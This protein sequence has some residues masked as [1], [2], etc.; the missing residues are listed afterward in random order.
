MEV[1]ANFE[2]F[3]NS[4]GRFR[5]ATTMK[6]VWCFFV[7]FLS[8]LT[9]GFFL[10]PRCACI[11][12]TEPCSLTCSL[13]MHILTMIPR[14]ANLEEPDF[15]LPNLI[16]TTLWD[17][18]TGHHDMF[19]DEFRE[20]YFRGV[21]DF[22]R[23]DNLHAKFLFSDHDISDDHTWV[24]DVVVGQGGFGVAGLWR[25]KNNEGASV[26]EVVIKQVTG[27][28]SNKDD[29]SE[30]FNKIKREAIVNRDAQR[31]A[32]VLL[33]A[34]K[35]A[36][37]EATTADH[38]IIHLRNY[39]YNRYI[40][41][42]RFYSI[43]APHY[44]L[45]D[46]LAR[47]RCWNAFVPELF[48]WHVVHSLAKAAKALSLP[49]HESSLVHNHPMYNN[50][51]SR[52]CSIIHM[53]LKPNNVFLDYAPIDDEQIEAMYSETVSDER[54]DHDPIHTYPT[55]KMA[56]FGLSVYSGPRNAGEFGGGT[57]GY[58][59]PE[60]LDWGHW[61]QRQNRP[62]NLAEAWTAKF[63][64]WGIGRLLFDF[65]TMAPSNT[66]DDILMMGPLHKFRQA[67]YL[68][69][70]NHFLPV[71]YCTGLVPYSLT[72]Q[73]LVRDCLSPRPGDRPDP[74]QLE[75]RTLAGLREARQR[76]YN[77]VVPRPPGHSTLYRLYYR[78]NE[79]EYMP[80]GPLPNYLAREEYDAAT[81]RDHMMDAPLQ[82]P[83]F[84][85]A[86]I[87]ANIKK[88]PAPLSFSK[89]EAAVQLSELNYEQEAATAWAKLRAGRAA[90][91]ALMAAR[92]LP[93][94]QTITRP[95]PRPIAPGPAPAYK[96]NPAPQPAPAR[97]FSGP[98]APRNFTDLLH[99]F[100][101]AEPYTG[102]DAE[103][104]LQAN[105][106][107]LP[108]MQGQHVHVQPNAVAEPPAA[109]APQALANGVLVSADGMVYPPRA[110][111]DST[112]VLD[113]TTVAPLSAAAAPPTFV[114]DLLV[115]GGDTAYPQRPEPTSTVA[116]DLTIN[117][118][119]P[120][121]N[122]KVKGKAR[123]HIYAEGPQTH[124][125]FPILPAP[126]VPRQ[127]AVQQPSTQAN[128]PPAQAQAQPQLPTP[129]QYDRMIV[130]EMRSELN[131]RNVILPQPAKAGGYVRKSEYKRKLQEA[132][133]AGNTGRGAWKDNAGNKWQKKR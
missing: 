33:Q 121:V 2:G 85:K 25:A 82:L 96:A 88:P 109:A 1:F 10:Q 87:D 13:E 107:V 36:G 4:D 9:L 108:Q 48:L 112:A 7:S 68:A 31:Q 30:F 111:P 19:S 116:V 77:G 72:L 100:Q 125:G 56:D 57:P 32:K 127:T 103:Q 113:L 132:D 12:L 54:P 18:K 15:S 45:D 94:S 98:R 124:E 114:N 101:P 83:T 92:A 123:G 8:F 24:P 119:E 93:A 106:F 16:L 104:A 34:K 6:Q 118:D 105:P 53:D 43:Y 120:R 89:I 131:H 79:I 42:C 71:R 58:Y 47:Y 91:G 52:E 44:T 67:D 55:I 40:K 97:P 37:K 128:P 74:D 50:G 73:T 14:P 64:I 70:D 65:V 60:H 126:R 110:R 86:W 29:T 81:Q 78:R 39:K 129:A 17:R 20:K 46:L 3:E 21:F 63:N 75:A 122:F 27:W 117:S 84:W 49:P 22:E 59:P 38:Q 41:T 80:P 133:Q 76:V 99:G 66:L 23:D 69:N 51:Y 5:R 61:F 28:K 102:R 130:A 26:D 95:A 62:I 11:I 35:D 115:S 90:F